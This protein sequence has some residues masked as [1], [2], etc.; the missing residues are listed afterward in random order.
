MSYQLLLISIQLL[1]R[2]NLGIRSHIGVLFEFQY[3]SCIGSISYFKW[4]SKV[5][6]KFQYNS[7]IGSIGSPI[8]LIYLLSIFQYNSCIGSMVVNGADVTT[9]M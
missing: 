5:F 7:C 2:F 1:Y 6:L 8:D 9:K 4:L 3:N